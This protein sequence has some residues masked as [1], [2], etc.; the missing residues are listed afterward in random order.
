MSAPCERRL[1]TV[2]ANE[3]LGAYNVLSVADPLPSAPQ[4]GQFAMLAAAERWG[5]GEDERPFLPRAFSYARWR[6]GVAQFVLED[7]GPGTRRL[8]ELQAGEGLLAL[9]P[10]GV[11]FEAP[12]EGRR[13]LLVGGGV[14]IAPLLIW[15]DQLAGEAAVLLGFRD[16]DRAQAAKLFAEAR[17]VTDDGSVGEQGLVSDLL[18]AELDEDDHATVY[19]CGPPAMLEA[20]RAICAERSVPCQLALESGMACGFGACYGCVVPDRDGG[21]LRVCVE[22]PVIDAERLAAVEAHAGAPA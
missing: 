18:R 16:A 15:Q 22:G 6:D 3:K 17:L 4:A 5:G 7:V 9:G 2:T 19:S 12:R 13:A 14:G 21:Y 11:G 20:V 10:L 1:L 8:C